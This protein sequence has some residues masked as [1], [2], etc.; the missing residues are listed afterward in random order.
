MERDAADVGA[1][2]FVRVVRVWRRERDSN[3]P[4][5]GVGS[6]EVSAWGSPGGALV[7]ARGG[8]GGTWRGPIIDPASDF[9]GESTDHL[10]CVMLLGFAGST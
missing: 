9:C 8:M 6:P 10:A 2:S 4:M 7:V 3:L 1:L 5:V